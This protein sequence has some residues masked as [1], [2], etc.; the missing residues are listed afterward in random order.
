MIT[1]IP[2][3]SYIIPFQKKKPR[4]IC[5]QNHLCDMNRILFFIVEIKF[6]SR[7]IIKYFLVFS[8]NKL[9]TYSIRNL[10]YLYRLILQN[11][12]SSV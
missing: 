12:I 3:K 7:K 11:S 4:K 2:I 1:E 6:A 8:L 5:L 9:N 10:S